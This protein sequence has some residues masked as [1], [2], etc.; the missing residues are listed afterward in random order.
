LLPSIY[1]RKHKGRSVN[2]ILYTI[3]EKIY[4]AW[5]SPELQIASLLLLDISR[6]FN[7][8][9]HAKLLHNFRKRKIDEKMVK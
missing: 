4:K 1:I 5:N 7:N 8:I 6:A 2:Y 9:S 3:I